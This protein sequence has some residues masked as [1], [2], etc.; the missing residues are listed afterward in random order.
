MRD[1]D[2]YRNSVLNSSTLIISAQ[3]D[4]GN[5]L[6][7]L[8]FQCGGLDVIERLLCSRSSSLED[9]IESAGVLAQITS[10]WIADNHKIEDLDRHVPAMVAALTGEFYVSMITTNLSEEETI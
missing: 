4:S 5:F 9:C 10:P 6:S 3:E 2:C 7:N 1:R 8:V